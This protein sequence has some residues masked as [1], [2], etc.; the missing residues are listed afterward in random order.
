MGIRIVRSVR[1]KVFQEWVSSALPPFY[2]RQ[3]RKSSSYSRCVC[4]PSA[5]IRSLPAPRSRL[6]SL[7][8]SRLPPSMS[9]SC[10]QPRKRQRVDDAGN[11]ATPHEHEEPVRYCHIE[12][13]STDMEATSEFFAKLFNWPADKSEPMHYYPLAKV[14]A[15]S[16]PRREGE[17]ESTAPAGS[18][19]APLR[20]ACCR[21]TLLTHSLDAGTIA[22]INVPD[23]HE[24][25]KRALAAGATVVT[26]VTPLES[27]GHTVGY[28]ATVK[29]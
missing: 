28:Y 26:P 3:G 1:P 12:Y 23:V 27:H 18:A 4:V 19:R 9:D 16:R 11:D 10:E 13:A 5:L 25:L 8:P 20:C 14:C 24:T 7:P 2:T 15:H 21:L 6:S 22:H 29:V 17:V